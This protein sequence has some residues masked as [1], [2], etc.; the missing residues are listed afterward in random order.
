MSIQI[1]RYSLAIS[2]I[3]DRI[4]HETIDTSL[5]YLVSHLSSLMQIVVMRLLL[6][7]LLVVS[8]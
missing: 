6:T 5:L 3:E 2:M 8:Q 1:A 4:E 7:F